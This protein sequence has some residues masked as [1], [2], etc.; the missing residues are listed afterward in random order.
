MGS[1]LFSSSQLPTKQR[2]E[3][4]E[5]R[6]GVILAYVGRWEARLPLGSESLERVRSYTLL[7]AVLRSVE[8]RGDM[9]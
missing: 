7:D 4:L 5:F 6:Y 9:S 3:N 8:W 2:P 1:R